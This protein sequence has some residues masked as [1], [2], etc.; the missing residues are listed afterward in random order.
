MNS[1]KFYRRSHFL[2][3]LPTREH[4][5]TAISKQRAPSS[6]SLPPCVVVVVAFDVSDACASGGQG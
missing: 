4:D 2:T 3:E 1:K 6:S 5:M